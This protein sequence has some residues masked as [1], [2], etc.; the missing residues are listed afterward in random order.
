[1]R[2][3]IGTM[4]TAL[5]I[6]LLRGRQRH[7]SHSIRMR[8]AELIALLHLASPSLPIGG[9]SYSQGLEAAI[10][11]GI[12]LDAGSAQQWIAAGLSQ[13]LARCELPFIAQQM[14]RW[15]ADDFDG[16]RQANAWF[17]ASRESAEFRQETEQMGWSLVSL[18]D[19]LECGNPTQRALLLSV[20]PVALPT[21]FAFVTH[22]R[23]ADPEAS[24]TAYAFN[25]VEN[26]VAAALKAVPLGQLAGQRILFG[27]HDAV[28]AAAAHALQMT[29]GDLSTFSPMLGIL[30][31][32]HESQ[33][34]RLFRS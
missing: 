27:L 1:M 4:N 12:I 7:S 3:R 15:Q 23:A 31:S 30:S 34:S 9:F 24:L 10:E 14:Q 8:P 32:R 6:R 2:I 18:C 25:W 26:Q 5:T 28:A 16:I 19:S 33:Y 13:V 11:A 22:A 29:P 20:K 21:A 17:L